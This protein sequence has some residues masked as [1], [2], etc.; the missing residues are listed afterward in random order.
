MK[1]LSSSFLLSVACLGMLASAAPLHATKTETAIEYTVQGSKAVGSALWTVASKTFGWTFGL[2][3]MA[4]GGAA[5]GAA[6]FGA[7]SLVNTHK[8]T[9]NQ[10]ISDNE[11]IQTLCILG[12]T[13]IAV[14]VG[15][16]FVSKGMKNIWN[17]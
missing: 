2:G 3:Q 9:Q 15:L 14:P 1:R 4:I 8:K 5:L 7:Y 13:A 17:A 11:L 10:N 16:I 12:G 6:G